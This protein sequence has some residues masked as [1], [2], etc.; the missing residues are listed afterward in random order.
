MHPQTF[1]IAIPVA[2]IIGLSLFLFG[3]SQLESGIRALGYDTLKRW[4]SRST[5]T[6]VGSAVTGVVATA[7]LQSSSLVSLLVLAFASAGTLPLYNGVGMLLGANLGT[8]VT[9]WMVATIGFKLSLQVFAL[10]LMATGGLMQLTSSSFAKLRGP[11]IA[12]FGLGL[13]IFGLDVMKGA[14][15]ELPMQW[16]LTVFRGQGLWLYF[17]VGTG[18]AALIQSSSATMMITLTA[19]HAGLLDV[20]SAAALMI[21]ADLGTTSTTALG[22]I[23]G[24]Y[25][26]R[27]LAL[28]QF[29]FNAIVD[30]AAFFLLLPLLPVLLAAVSMSD[31]LYSLVAFHSLFNLI[32]LLAFMPFLKPFSNWIGHRFLKP[33]G[34]EQSLS[35]QPVAVPEAALLAIERVLSTMRLNAV[36]LGLH[37]FKLRPEQLQLTGKMASE[38]VSCTS[39]HETVDQRY[40]HIKQQE[41]ELLSFSFD[42]QSQPLTLEQV[43]QLERQTREARAMVYS[44]KT[45]NDIRENLVSLRHASQPEIIA[46]YTHHREHMKKVYRHYL[47]LANEGVSTPAI[48]ETLTSQLDSNEKHYRETNEMVS[49]MASSDTVAGIE[50]STMLNVNREVHHSLKN[51][52]LSMQT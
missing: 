50:L 4:F 9:G 45:L 42:L 13:I 37:A 27:Q 39:D 14:V 25:I 43:A 15:A 38:L 18:I 34:V 22:S 30:L 17:L 20:S 5:A 23:G 2:V 21:G 6:P 44:S 11:G 19:L 32:G 41:S 28:A 51:L 1:D 35:T 7:I 49:S 33:D 52:F 3:M 10:P 48:H 16:D 31:P 29:L 40:R 24:H 12:L 46:W 47:T 36:I 8:T 26:K